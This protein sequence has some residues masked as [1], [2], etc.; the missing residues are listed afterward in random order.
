MAD[1]QDNPGIRLPPP[2]IYLLPLLLGLLLD[3]KS[4]VPSCHARRR[5]A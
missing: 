5:E 4:H 3:R 2:L 1:N